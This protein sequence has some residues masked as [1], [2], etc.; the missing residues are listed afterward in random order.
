MKLSG[1]LAFLILL[2]LTAVG[3]SVLADEPPAETGKEDSAV[4]PV[5]QQ[6]IDKRESTAGQ[7]SPKPAS[8]AVTRGQ[9]A[10][11]GATTK[12]A[13]G[14]E[15]PAATET[16]DDPV[17]FDSSGNVQVYIHLENTDVE[18]LQQLRD[19]GATLEVT[20]SGLNVVQAWV[21]ISSL[22]QIAALDAVQEITPPDYGV[23]KTGSI[24]TEGDAIHRADLVRAFSGLTGAGVKVGVISDGVDSWTTSRSRGDLPGNIEMNPENEGEGDEGT[25]LLE[26]V[27]DLAPNARLAFSGAGTSL[28]FVE[29]TLWLA[30]EAFGGEGADVIVDDLGYYLQPYYEDGY[31]ALAVAD[32][33]AGGAVFVSAAGNY[34][35]RHYEGEFVDGGD[36]YHDF[37]HSGGTDIALR[38]DT[39]DDGTSVILQ[40]NDRFGASTNDY[41]LYV[42]P[43]GLKPVK[44]NLQNDICTGSNW[45]Q[46]EGGNDDPYE[47]VFPS[48]DGHTEADVYI[49]KHSGVTKSL[50]LFVPGG[51]ILEHRV[52][53]GGIVGHPAVAEVLAVGAIR[54]SDPGNDDPES[55]SDRGP[56]V[57]IDETRNKPDVMGINGV[58]I[59]GSGGFGEQYVGV[60]GAAFFGTSA[61]APHVAGIAAL[62]MEAQRRATPNA[63][64]KQVADA[65]TQKLRDTAIDLGESGRDNTFG[66]GRADA[67][68]AIESIAESSTTFSV[69]SLDPFPVTYTVNSTGDGADSSTSDGVCDDGTVPGSTYCTLRA[70][71]QQANAGSGAVIKFDISGG[72]YT[73]QPDT[74]LPAITKPVFIDGYSQPAASATNLLIE[75]IGTNAGTNTSGLTLSGKG[76]YVRGLAVNRFNGNGIVLQGRGGGQVLV[77]N[78]I[79]TDTAGAT[80]QGNGAAGVHIDGA[81]NVVLRDNV[82]SGNTTYGVHIS[83]GRASGAVLYGNMIGTSAS[84]TSDL[85]NTLAGVYVN[86]AE[87]TTLRDNVISGNDSHG[88]SLSGSGATNADIQYNLIGVSAS[89]TSDLGNT[90]AGIHISGGRNTGIFEN[91]IGGNDSHGISL[92]GSG[93]L[94]TFVGENYIGTNASGMSLGNGGAGVHIANSSYNN[95]IEVNTIAHNAGDGVTVT[96]SGSFGNTIWE[97]STHSNGGLG[98][99]LNDDGVTANDSGD[100]D[101]G[102]NFLQNFPTLT[103]FATRSDAASARFTLD[104]TANRRYI[105]DFYANDSCDASGNGEGKQWLGFTP[106]LPSSSG[107]GTF[108]SSTLQRTIGYYSAPAGNHI[109][110]TATDTLLNTTSEFSACV[111][112]V[113][114]PELVISKNPVVVTEGTTTTYTVSL[115]STP[116]AETKVALSVDDSTVA[117]LS[118]D[119][120]TFP[121]GNNNPQTVTVTPVSDNDVDNDATEIRHSVSIGDHDYPTAVLPVEVTDDDAPTLTLT[122]TTTD[123]DITAIFP[124]ATVVAVGRFF[125]GGL[126]MEEG[127]A[128]TYTVVLKDEPP[129]DVTVRLT[130]SDTGAMTV[131]PPAM[132]FT[133]GSTG[134]WDDPQTATLTAVTDSDA[135]DEIEQITHEMTIAGKDYTLAQ[136]LA[137]VRDLGLPRLTFDPDTRTVSVN[138]GG[139]AMYS[140]ALASDPGD[141]ATATVSIEASEDITIG[142]AITVSPGRLS[143]TGGPSGN[144]GTGQ[145]VTVTGVEDADEFDNFALIEHTIT[146]GTNTIS[147]PKVL[148]TVSD[149]NRA[150][151]F[152]EGL[153]TTRDVPEYAGAGA[154]VGDPV[155]ATDLNTGDTLTYEMEDTSGLFAI[156]NDGQITVVADDSLNYE[157]EADYEI[158]VTVR[159]R[160]TDGL[161]D[162][163]EVKVRVTDVNEPPIITGEAMPTFNENT[164]I[165][166][167]VARYTATDP[168][169]D[170]FTWTVDGTDKDAFTI[171]TSGN[172][173]FNSQPDHE[174]KNAYRIEIVATDDGDPAAAGKFPVT[175]SV[176]NV[177]EAPE[178]HLGGASHNYS[179]NDI[180]PVQQYFARDPEGTTTFSWTLG[181]TDRG[182]FTI[183]N[184][185][186]E[187]ANIPDYERPADSGGDNVYNVQVRASDGSLTGTK[188]VTVTVE[189]L[190]EAPVISGDDTLS[191]PENTAVARVLDRYSAADPERGQITWSL[192]GTDPGA[193]RID[194]SGNLYFAAPP[195][196]DATGTKSVYEISVEATDDGTLG[197]RTPSTRGAMTGT[198][199][200]TV[201]VTPID[202]PPVITGTTILDKWQE[203]DTSPIHTYIAVDPEGNTPITW[204]LDGTDR[205]DFNISQDGELTFR[206]TPNYE[207]PADSNRNNEYL[208]TVRAS[209]GQYTGMLNVTVTVRDV[210]EAP[211]LDGPD[212][213]DDFP[214]N[215]STSRQVARYTASD[216]ERATV[217][218]SLTGTDSDDFTLASNGVLTFNTSPDYE[219]QSSY[220]VTVRAEAGIHTGNSATRKRVTVNLQN[221]EE[222]GTVTLSAVQPQ[223][224]T[225]L[226]AT[227]DD[228]DDPTGIT[229]QWYRTSSRGSTGTAI[230]SATFRFYTPVAD[231]VG[232]YLRAVASYDDGHGTGK[233]ASAVS[234]NRVQAAPPDPEP[235]VF[236]VDGNYD[237]SIRE[238]TRAGTN[239]GAPVRATDANNDRLT[240]SIPESDY[241]EVDA[242]S[243]QLRTKAELDHE[244]EDEYTVTV[245]ATDP[246]GGTGA[247]TVTITVTD[248]NEGPEVS[249]RNSYTVEENQEL[250]GAEFFATDPEGDSVAR[251]SLS[252][253]DGGDF[254]I[255]E[256]G[257]L[258]FRNTPNYESPSDSNRNNEYLVTVRASDGQYTGTLNV[259]VT[260][261]D[262]NEAPEFASS[263]KSRTSFTYPENNTHALYTY[264]ATDPEGRTITWSVSGT[265]GGDFDISVT[266]VLTFADVPDFENP[267]DANRDNEYLVTVQAQDDG[268]NFDRLEVTVNVTNSAGTEEPTITTTSRPALTFQENGTGAVY[269]Y[270]A[271]D[272]QRG[273]I[274]W[275]VAGTDARAFTITSDSSGRGVLTFTSPPDFENPTDSNRDNLYEIAVVATDE[276]GLTDNFDVTVTVAN[277]AESVEPTISTRRPPTTYQEN[278]TATVYNFRASDP[279]RGPITWSGTGTDASAFALSDSGALSFVSPPDFESPSDLDR[280]NDY[281]LKVVA[282]DEDG[283]S[284]S[285]AFTITVTDVNEGP[286]IRRVGS[287][288]GGVAENQDQMQVLARYTATDPEDTGA[289]ITLWST[290]GMDGGDF[291]IN[292]H[293]ELRF[294]YSP[295]YERPADS[296][297]DNIYE[298]T[299]R[300]SD[301]RY[302]GTHDVTVTVTPVNEAPTI[303]TTSSSAT[304]LRQPENRTSRLYTYR[305]TDPEGSSI[306]W[307]VGGADGRFFTID[308]RGQFSFSENSPP[309]FEIP[310]DSGG[311]NIYNVT[312]QASDGTHTES[313]AVMV[314]ITDVNE[315]PE[316]SGTQTLSL[317]ENRATEQVLASYTGSDPESPGTPINRWS[318]SGTDGGDFTIN[319]SGELTFR[320]VPDYERPVD[321]N[322]DNIYAFSVRAYDGRY[323]GSHEV[324]V[325]VDNLD[326]ISGPSAL[327]RSENFEGLL[328]TYSATGRGDLTV[329]PTWR[330]TGTDG[331]DFSISEQGELTFRS[332]PD[333]ERPADSNRDNVYS[334]A[335]QV[336]DGGYYGS[337]DVT[338]TVTPVNEAPT[339]TTISSSATGLRQPENRTSRLY[340]YRATDPEGG[341]IA[342]SVGGTDGRFFTIDQRGE[343]S[344]SETSPPDFEFPGDLGGDNIYNVTVQA[345]DGTHTGSVAVMVNVTDVN[346]GPTVSGSETLSSTENRSTEQVLA[347]YTGSDPESPGTPI[348]RWSTS[349]TDGG[350]FT[351]NE[352]GE[353]KFRNTPDYERP[354]DSNRDNI[355]T[356]SVRAY[357]GRY[358]GHLEVT[359]TVD[360]LDEI[361]GPSA[362]DRPENFE[363]LLSTYSATGRG[364]LTVVPTWRL[365]GTD[366][367]DFSISEQGELTF[368]STPDYE[369]PADSN[370]DNVYSLAVQV[371]DG[372]YYGSRDVT[373]TVTP[374]NEAPTITT[375]SSSAT[376]LRQP[377]NRTSRL[378]TYRATD[379]EGGGIAWSVGGAD[380]RFFTIDERGQFSF[381]ETSPPDFEFPGD[382]GG[383]NIYNVTVQASDGTHTG[384]VA[385]MVNV[386][387]VNEGPTVSG[388]ETLSSTENRATEQVLASYTGSDP[389]SPGTPINRW[390]TSGTD[391][392]DFTINESGEL[393]FRNTPD[394]ERPADSNRDNIYNFSVRAYDGRYY[395][396][397]EVTVTVRDVNEAPTITTTSRTE[398]S[399]GEN[400][401]STIYTFRATDPEGGTVTWSA[402]GP[403]G[404]DFTIVGG[405]LRFG[406]EPDFESPTGTNGNEY[407]VTVRAEDAQG[408]PDTLEV[409]VTVTAVD[410]GP[411][412]TSGGNSFTV[413]ENQEWTGASFRASDPES[414]TVSRWRLAGRDGGDFAISETGLMT[415]R[416]IPDYERPADSNRDNLYE[417]TVQP[418]D[419]RNYGSHDVTVTVTP[420]NEPPSITT[421]GRTSF[422]QPENRIS[423]LYTFRATDPEGGDFEWDLAGPDA[424]DFSISETGVLTFSSPPDFENPLGTNRNEYQVTVQAR[425]QQ[426]NT[427]N[428]PVTVTVTDQNEGPEIRR[429]GNAPG[430]VPENQDQMQV[431][432]RY[433][434]TDPEDTSAQITLWSTSGTDGGDFVINEQGELRFRNSPDH[435][436]PADSN[437]DNVYEVSIRA[438]DGRNYG[439][440]EDTEMVRVTNVNEAPVITTKSRTGFTQRENATSALHTYRATDPDRDDAITWSVEGSDRDDFAIYDGILTFRLL[441][442]YEIPADSNGDNEYEITVVASDS[443]NLRDTVEAIITITEVNEGPEVSG[444]QAYTVV[445]GQELIGASFTAADP[446]GDDVTRWSLSGSDGGD[447]EISETGVLT[448]RNVPD[449]DRPADSNRDNEYLVSIRV[450]D[451]GNRYGSLDVTVTVTDVNEEAPVVTGSDNRTVSE[452]TTSAIHT[453]WATDA[454]L[455]DTITW[456]TS[457]AD[458]QLFEMNEQGA[459]SFREAPDYENPRDSDRD[460][461]YELNV[462]ATDSEGLTGELMVTITVTEVNEGPEITGTATYTIQEFHQN[463]VNATYS[464]TDPEGDSISR[465]RLSGSDG[466]DFTITDT[467]EQTGRNTADLRFRYPPDVDRPA[468]SNRDNEYLVTIRAYDNRGRYGSYDVTVIVTAANEP[469]VITGSDART[470]RENG[471]GT[472]HTYRATDPEGDDFSWIPPGGMDGHLFD[473]SDRGALTFRTPPDFDIERDANG[474]NDYQVTVQARD[475]SFNTG[476]FDVTV[477]V[478]DVN[479]GPEVSGRETMTVQEYTDPTQDPA[480][481]TLETY[482]ARDPEGSDIS[483]WSLSGID[484][485]D[486]SI[487]DNGELTF[488]YAPDYDRPVDSNRDNEYLVSVRAYDE[489]NRYG[490]LD[491][492]VT[493]RGENEA[494]PVVT[495]SQ[496][497]SFRENTAVTTR[498]YTYRATDTDRDTTIVWSVR[499]QDGGDFDIDSD[500]G[501]LTFKE[502]PDY[503]I[504]ADSDTNNEYLVTVVATDDEG[505]EGTLDVV[506]TVTEV[507]EGPEITAPS[508]QTEFTYDENV[509]RVVATLTARDP[510]DPASGISRWSLAGSDGGDFTITDTS[511]Q[512]GRNTAQLTFRNTPDYERPADSNRDNEYLVTIRA[513]DQGNRYGSL[514]VKIAVIDENEHA[515]VVTGSQALSFQENT[516]TTTRLHTYRARDMDRGAVITWSLE[517]DDQGDFAI[518]EG[519]LTFNEEPDYEDPDDVNDDNEYEITVVASDGTNRGTLDVSIMVTEVNEGPEITGPATRTVA[520]NFEDMVATYTGE[521]PED[522]A[523]DINRWSV[524]GRDG[525]DFTIN[526]GGELTFRNPPDFERPADANRDNEYEVTVR[527]SDGR[528]YGTYDVTVTVEAVNEAPEFRSGSRTSFT[529]R[530][531]GTSDLYTYRATDPEGDEFTWEAGGTDG[532]AF[533][534]SEDGGVLAFKIPPDFENPGDFDGDNEYLVTVVVRD[535]Q[536]NMS[537]LEVLVAVTE[538]NEGPEIQE[539]PAN[540][541]I[542][543]SE[544]SEG[545]LFDYSATDPEDP[546]AEITRW[547]VT[548]TDGGDFT[549]NEDGELSFRNVPDFERPV[550]SNRDNEYLVTVRASDGRYN[551]TL[552]VTVRGGGGKRG[553]GIQKRQHCHLRIPGEWDVQPVYLPR[554]GSGRK[555]C[556][557]G[558]VG[559]RPWR[560]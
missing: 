80:D 338:V 537:E 493:V 394:Y 277:H 77:G 302:Y 449:Y 276:Q 343:F 108:N 181:G 310:G 12:D 512:T 199:D 200:V 335:V 204:T 9:Y 290:S 316:I 99:D 341:G 337:R 370:R 253:T 558:P 264:Q 461:V 544:N 429:L 175:V 69:D 358:Y 160:A 540:T 508:G 218:L 102:P 474:D 43:P 509:D 282:T 217:T 479:E 38:I 376:G 492:T 439:T 393:K 435:E 322:R 173:R 455:G 496:S 60:S 161:T 360:D 412:V 342:W 117:I 37:D 399:H 216:P 345:S 197:D 183:T 291:V 107:L 507:P 500:D 545:V 64:K 226:T 309:D 137:I 499:G 402:G 113:D 301:G 4:S 66:Y 257:V 497:L 207:S 92:T 25:A 465:W 23:T 133:S 516:A 132:T 553:A 457:G 300:A 443:G 476:A 279:Q 190:N 157:A 395:G 477:T 269:S 172:L 368:R 421:T 138:E 120:L 369:R 134:T 255:N 26:I 450:Y 366:G 219:D 351:I 542:T 86:G 94:D 444:R 386:A 415:F 244:D 441:P 528:H 320:N 398:F 56:S 95:F 195:D 410:E 131:A 268:F 401:T 427:S 520:E 8:D 196:L 19:L 524:T 212:T 179:E 505:R 424:S 490:S 203:N 314:N 139:T 142:N 357:D 238:N 234:A 152:E 312:V 359:V 57:L 414:G 112:R 47:F 556:G 70:A 71:I 119:V 286:E 383:D 81:P 555:R 258:T 464:A 294:R 17:R 62:I 31:V 126:R 396:Y 367:G 463:L 242:S 533:E 44:F 468:D 517:G 146:V 265:D 502:A 296:N 136:V 243:G 388:S 101:S 11:S 168:E 211:M 249:G 348:N 440:F 14:A 532:G 303:T 144:W 498:L 90:M 317:D 22:D 148:V 287:A 522:T 239:L 327:D 85:G 519:V 188:D 229:W 201:T 156:D 169:R 483:R 263:S 106:V 236:P 475:D 356:L 467:S 514:D 434:A 390:S 384:S 127:D 539:T 164:G 481:Q 438:S 91:V 372:G 28:L 527:A 198:F 267:V 250:S 333:Y 313:L 222:R 408:N 382:S 560:F 54:A 84:G 59:T 167:R 185:L 411:E 470:F 559:N 413:Q 73:I 471:T 482:S 129:A 82:I 145:D 549:I 281:E 118:T 459:L 141:G 344:F 213:V 191:Y 224:R 329:V 165:T 280:Q 180:H 248:V 506:V 227:L 525:G 96:A 50:E 193:F 150:P 340:T 484:G 89:G 273:I 166:N 521:D 423:T 405:A 292:E 189:D 295:D 543:V 10:D 448:F 275:S 417:V 298:M 27:H 453:Y 67:L 202:E 32:T 122:N 209:D 162:K 324:T 385:V 501:V 504:P 252:G 194:Q 125:D 308:E 123:P 184:G 274:T 469:P 373:V 311:D 5:L 78:R 374:V 355:Y 260:V 271:N 270:N 285:L 13:P 93:T 18:T 21:P 170:S 460:N 61:A 72:S 34:A 256:T 231:D 174:D 437:R 206:N 237:R 431:L 42:C 41:D 6:F 251:W 272:P 55:F 105:V 68:A 74:T 371:S 433:T 488:R 49:R 24:N 130:S 419:G 409:T 485:G 452:N 100:T 305:A 538:L 480:L 176:T 478:T 331:G 299:V 88:V 215:A 318:T 495:G 363:G 534:I 221:V 48:F 254:S 379:P 420:V 245:T 416:T 158:Q 109:T 266:G 3:A 98:I 400:G 407:Q 103:A 436:R 352:S 51:R 241:F 432:A 365:T 462:V 230:T 489:T 163:I 387:D 223:E 2:W 177:N 45:S 97:N 375:T 75:L 381:S 446:E 552:E 551:G 278:G 246:G 391:G 1:A 515:P 52:E 472:I 445:E 323:Y 491:V 511:Q 315:G 428:L 403:D 297:R 76:S 147:R 208:V 289:Q 39:G 326:E 128:A 422:T 63:T 20:N 349:G 16:T 547:S 186:L 536:S 389:E 336:S 143:F 140:V 306:T 350:D 418:Y 447:F 40:W 406:T 35:Q 233:T 486:F 159:D 149:E 378:Y 262:V 548:G 442:D 530:E 182:D 466:G 494:D 328:S 510:E 154:N 110:A 339:I 220:S 523:A 171:D 114:L 192:S 121:T 153:D 535:D 353:L 397:H 116:S 111:T 546:D 487:N 288:P 319:E 210:N 33:V 325:T 304:G 235:P 307:S 53:E 36:G 178:I 454:D 458:G 531:N 346:E 83:G 124:G 404:G 557:M 550:D 232:S 518:D 228:D 65:V 377:E 321:S 29:A 526:E 293:G 240:Y 155:V 261:R 30:N 7:R 283:H 58:S 205:G 284:D 473:I 151:F 380:G 425:D 513:Y 426:S 104:V 456:S 214:E 247:V 79:G 115:P 347:S 392:G 87:E 529:H 332:T 362:L 451:A 46:Q 15:S 364:G 430:S 225:G 541:D 354:A 361:S 135:F 187:F 503:E 330:L 334:I 554:Y 259:T